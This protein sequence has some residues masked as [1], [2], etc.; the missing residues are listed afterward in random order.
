MTEEVTLEEAINERRAEAKEAIPF[1]AEV[2]QTLSRI[3]VGEHIETAEVKKEGRVLYTYQYLTW[4]WAWTTLM[5]NYPESEYHILDESFLDNGTVMVNVAITVKRNGE[6]VS[7]VCWLPVMDQSNNAITNPTTRHISDARMRCIVK[8]LAFGFGLGLDLWA[9]SDIPV[10]AID[11]PIT[12]VQAETIA[13]LLEKSGSNREKF[14]EWLE[15][16]SIETIKAKDYKRALH[17]LERAI[18]RQ[19]S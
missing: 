18:K 7:K 11:D 16:E 1:V 5:N 2:W 6:K 8:C 4:S 13:G 12:E 10:G 14:L 9:G 3:D 19:G 15:A 17:Q